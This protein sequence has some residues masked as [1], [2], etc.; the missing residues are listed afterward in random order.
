MTPLL[1]AFMA[2]LPAMLLL[3]RPVS[4]EDFPPILATAE[5]EHAWIVM[6]K[7]PNS[8]ESSEPTSAC[9]LVPLLSWRTVRTQPIW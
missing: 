9:Y 6:P 5:G 8:T 4:A 2:V 7:I 3:M 1:R